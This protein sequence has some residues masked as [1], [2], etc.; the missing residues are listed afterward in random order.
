MSCSCSGRHSMVTCM[1]D[2]AFKTQYKHPCEGRCYDSRI[3]HLNARREVRSLVFTPLF[4]IASKIINL[5]KTAQTSECIAR[6]CAGGTP[7][8]QRA[9]TPCYI[10]NAK[11]PTK[12]IVDTTH[13]PASN[14]P[15]AAFPE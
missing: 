9:K 13:K 7:A 4:C 2:Y 14:E 5:W 11:P 3:L 6:N 12:T 15:G 1:A 8:F 10:G